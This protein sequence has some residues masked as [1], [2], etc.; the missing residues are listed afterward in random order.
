MLITCLGSGTSSSSGRKVSVKEMDSLSF[1]D[2]YALTLIA[3]YPD[4][5][6]AD[7]KSDLSEEA[8]KVADEITSPGHAQG[9]I[10][11]AAQHLRNLAKARSAQA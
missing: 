11:S 4:E 10:K 2:G 5:D 3:Q 6:W 1:A 9:E 8:R 7:V